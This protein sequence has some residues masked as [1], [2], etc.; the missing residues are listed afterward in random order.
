MFWWMR[1]CSAPAQASRPR[2]ARSRRRCAG[3]HTRRRAATSH[4]ISP[5]PT[6]RCTGAHPRRRDRVPHRRTP[7]IRGFV[8]RRCICGKPPTGVIRSSAARLPAHCPLCGIGI[9]TGAGVVTDSRVGVFGAVAAGKTDLILATLSDVLA[10]SQRNSV[11][12]RTVLEQ[13]RSALNSCPSIANRSARPRRWSR[14]RFSD[15]RRMTR[16]L[17]RRVRART[18]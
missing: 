2:S 4:H 7:G 17:V 18:P 6:F 11:P 9:G 16:A 8:W 14:P 5:F 12:V 1:S 10:V 15:G 13:I 3:S